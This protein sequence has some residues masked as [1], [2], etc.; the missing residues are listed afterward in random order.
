MRSPYRDEGPRIEKQGR[1][2]R[3][4][5]LPR[6]RYPNSGASTLQGDKA[7]GEKRARC[8]STVACVQMSRT[9]V[10]LVTTVTWFFAGSMVVASAGA[11]PKPSPRFWSAGYCERVVPKEHPGVRQI[12]CVGS[13]GAASCRWT[14][15]YRGRVYTKLRVFAWYR[16]ADFSSLGMTEL[17]PGVVRSFTLATRA[18]PGFTRIVHLYG[19]AYEGW[20][21]DFWMGHVRL[22]GT[23]VNKHAFGAFV[24]TRVAKLTAREQTV[25][26]SDA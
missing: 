20:P 5:F 4:Q 10:V 8:V 14:S 2:R 6:L 19:D 22:L 16:H 17:E 1:S 24:A 23:H 9:M 25:N 3:F 13:G 12:V 7:A 15:G 11:V 18:Q 21:A 26:C